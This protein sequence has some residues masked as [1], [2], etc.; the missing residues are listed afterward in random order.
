MIWA[1]L[2]ITLNVADWIT[3]KRFL[4]LGFKEK[5]PILRK[6]IARWGMTGVAVVKI[7]TIGL[8]TGIVF[9]WPFMWPL[10][11]VFCPVYAYVVYN[12]IKLIK[13]K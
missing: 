12:N 1:L 6:V 3:T 8:I 7:I 11:A 10:A 2:L 5:N 4:E 13:E 9:I